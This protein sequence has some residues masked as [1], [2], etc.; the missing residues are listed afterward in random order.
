[1][2]LLCVN[3]TT[4]LGLTSICLARRLACYRRGRTPRIKQ[5]LNELANQQTR[6]SA[7]L[8][9]VPSNKSRSYL[10]GLGPVASKEAIDVRGANCHEL[11]IPLEYPFSLATNPESAG[12]DQQTQVP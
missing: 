2:Y 9:Q 12:M 5:N 3:G 11:R 1:M 10:S 8:K 7:R 6:P 4:S